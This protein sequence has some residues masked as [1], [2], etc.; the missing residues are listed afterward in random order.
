[1]SNQADVRSI[2]QLKHFKAALAVY[3][4]DTMAAIGAVDMEA[5]RVSH[6][7]QHDRPAFWREQIKKRREAV[8]IAKAEVFR[9]QLMKTAH[10][11]PSMSEQKE[12]L[13]QA[14]AS[15]HEAEMRAAMVKKYD[16]ILRQAIFEYQGSVRRIKDLAGG[17]ILRAA[18]RLGRII[19]ALESY[20]S[21]SPPSLPGAASPLE[22]IADDIFREDP[23]PH[24]SE[25]P[26]TEVEEAAEERDDA[27]TPP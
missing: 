8:S 6:W 11:N 24:R 27:E 22:S 21:L 7:L 26:G 10:N 2:E 12:I 25:E 4:E 15:L 19:E 3:S 20:L 13:R 17:D 23:E 16:P 5:R 14:E 1:M 9:R 18:Q